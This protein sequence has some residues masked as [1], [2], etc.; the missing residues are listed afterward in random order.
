MNN[1]WVWPVQDAAV[2]A[3]LYLLSFVSTHLAEDDRANTSLSAWTWSL[4]P[5]LLP[6]ALPAN[7]TVSR[8]SMQCIKPINYR[9]VRRSVNKLQLVSF[10]LLKRFYNNYLQNTNYL[11][12][13]LRH[14]ISVTDNY[15]YY[16]YCIN[17]IIVLKFEEVIKHR[18]YYRFLQLHYKYRALVQRHS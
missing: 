12:L 5:S 15:F 1:R 17:I 7:Y 18:S 4:T 16:L 6:S 2:P 13:I 9:H 10:C 14:C 3:F 8:I 11:I